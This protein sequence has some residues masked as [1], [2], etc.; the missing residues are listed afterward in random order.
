MENCVDPV[1]AQCFLDRGPVGQVTDYQHG[2]FGH[3]LAMA[4]QQG[5]E[6]DHVVF[7]LEK[8]LRCRAA[9]ESSTAGYQDS[10]LLLPL[11][12]SSAR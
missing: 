10:H 4:T 12:C 6:H 1:V 9:D 5:V 2:A 11:C 3:G 8:T 7:S